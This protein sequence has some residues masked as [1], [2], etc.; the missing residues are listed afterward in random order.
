VRALWNDPRIQSA[1]YLGHQRGR[2]L[3]EIIPDVFPY[4]MLSDNEVALWGI[5]YEELEKRKPK[6]KR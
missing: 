1:C 5:F 6:V 3:Y 4:R 2:F